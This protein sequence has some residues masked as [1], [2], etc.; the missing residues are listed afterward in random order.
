M[1]APSMTAESTTICRN[2]H[3]KRNVAQQ[4]NQQTVHESLSDG[5]TCRV[6]DKN[7]GPCDLK[8]KSF[9][10]DTYKNTEI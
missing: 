4:K 10:R 5:Q 7:V 1:Q 3:V 9:Q 2:E 6:Q 8:L